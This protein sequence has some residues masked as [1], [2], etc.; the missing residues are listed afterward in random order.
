MNIENLKTKKIAILG[1]GREGKSTLRFLKNIGAIDITILDK[2]IETLESIEDES[3]VCIWWSSYL[4]SLS[5]FD[6]I[7]KSP[8]VCPYNEDLAPYREKFISQTQVFY[9]NYPGKVIAVT[10]TKGKSTTSTLIYLSL[11]EAGYNVKLVGNIWNPVFDEID[12][13]Q[14]LTPSP[15]GRELGW[16]LYDFIVYEMSSYMLEWFIPKTYISVFNNIY[17]CHLDWHRGFENYKTAKINILRNSEHALINFEFKDFD[18][19]KTLSSNTQF[20]WIDGDFSYKNNWFYI[21]DERVLEDENI[22]LLGEHN[23]KNIAWV[24]GVV[25]RAT[26]KDTQKTIW[27]VKK[28]ISTFE[29][30]P[31]RMEKVGTFHGITFIN[32]AIATTPESTLAAIK[33]FSPDIGTLFLWGYDSG[34]IYTELEKNIEL[35]NIESLVLFPDTG[36]KIF[37]QDIENKPE[38]IPFQIQKNGR[39]I[40]ILKTRS[41]ETAVEFAYE[42]TKQWK[43]ALLSNASQSFSLWKSYEVKGNLFKELVMN[44]SK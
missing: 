17:N 22:V 8:W 38:E 36:Y 16:G 34:F 14:Y 42:Y 20:F 21:A 6:I 5:D 7:F 44:Y 2:N 25:Y 1:Y 9:E 11:K 12:I 41:M 37:T 28:V 24:L 30:L 39:I 4:D 27:A 31:H 15:L 18:E 33:T 3:V 43:I 19:V 13:L 35:G 32:D 29:W 40:N 23:R 10:G 26:G